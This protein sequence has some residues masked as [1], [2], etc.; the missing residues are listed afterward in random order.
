MPKCVMPALHKSPYFVQ[1]GPLADAI[2]SLGQ[3]PNIL[4]QGARTTTPKFF[5]NF[6]KLLGFR[7]KILIALY[8]DLQEA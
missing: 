3:T 1:G 7:V 2:L 5:P 6:S 4:P 8:G